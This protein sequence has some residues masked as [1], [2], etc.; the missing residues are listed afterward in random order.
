MD[1]HYTM[2]YDY[3]CCCALKPLLHIL[4]IVT[5]TYHIYGITQHMIHLCPQLRAVAVGES[6]EPS[7]WTCDGS[8]PL[9]VDGRHCGLTVDLSRCC[10]CIVLMR[11]KYQ[12]SITFHIHGDHCLVLGSNLP[13]GLSTMLHQ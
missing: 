8:D 3:K 4:Y 7:W 12:L 9:D 1:H 5:Y 10:R 6:G 2:A 11:Q 13:H